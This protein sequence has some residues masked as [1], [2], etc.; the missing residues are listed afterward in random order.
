MAI[1]EWP[2]ASG[3]S[4]YVLFIGLMPVA[5]V[6]NNH[7]LFTGARGGAIADNIRIGTKLHL[8]YRAIFIA[9]SKL[10]FPRRKDYPVRWRR[11]K[12][13]DQTGFMRNGANKIESLGVSGTTMK[14]EKNEFLN[15]RSM[16]KTISGFFFSL[17]IL[18]R[19]GTEEPGSTKLPPG[20]KI[21]KDLGAVFDEHVK[22]EFVDK[23]VDATMST[24]TE[25]PYVHHVATA[26]GGAG[27]QGV[28]DFYAN[29][30]IG[31]WP[32]D[33]KV[34]P[35]S[36]TIGED[37]V[38]DE[39]TLNFTHDVQLDFMLPEIAPTVKRVEL[40]VVVI[41]KF[42]NGK[43]AHEHIYWDQGSLL[44]QVG[45]LDP[46]KVPVLGVDQTQKLLNLLQRKKTANS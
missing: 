42:E 12:R 31:K 19:A 28:R 39:L 29:H 9:Q 45:L 8:L 22:H 1:A 40:S 24:M 27:R 11:L 14:D 13:G 37:C 35:V 10:P 36:R 38:V 2:T 15:R 32:A 46:Q 25:D 23:D 21:S 17:P 16:V 43:V 4:D 6:V 30:F 33:V 5:A 7:E 20:E 18:A 41:V 26:T 3:S 34:V 44:A